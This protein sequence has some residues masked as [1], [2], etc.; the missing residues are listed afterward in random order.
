MSAFL[1]F[2]QKKHSYVSKRDD[3]MSLRGVSMSGRSAPFL[4]FTF[5]LVQYPV[6][7]MM[8]IGESL[9]MMLGCA[10]E[11]S[12]GVQLWPKSSH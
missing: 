4:R 11:Q 12:G 5:T 9:V 10:G 8:R 6:P 7:R 3:V 1:R 2:V